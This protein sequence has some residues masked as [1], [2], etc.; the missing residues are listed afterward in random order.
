MMVTPC[1]TAIASGRV[2]SQLPPRSAREVDDHRARRHPRHHLVGD[3]DRRLLARDDRGRD[4]DVAL[5]DDPPEQ[6]ALALVERLILRR[7]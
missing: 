5:G 2:S 7:A 3:Q 1:T 6:L 4:D